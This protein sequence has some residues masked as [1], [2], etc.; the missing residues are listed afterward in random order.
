MSHPSLLCHR[1]YAVF[2][3]LDCVLQLFKH[4][5]QYLRAARDQQ[6]FVCGTSLSVDELAA[7]A[8]EARFYGL[9]NLERAAADCHNNVRFEYKYLTIGAYCTYVYEPKA[10]VTLQQKNKYMQTV[11]PW[12]AAGARYI[13][14]HPSAMTEVGSWDL[15]PDPGNLLHLHLEGWEFVHSTSNTQSQAYSNVP[16]EYMVILRRRL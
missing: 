8:A 12:Q 5:L 13:D 16:G 10:M 15:G 4:V 1:C 2:H 6:R 3:W 14:E 7:I 11:S 9:A